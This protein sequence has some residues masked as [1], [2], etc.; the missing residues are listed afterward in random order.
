MATTGSPPAAI[1]RSP[2]PKHWLSWTT[3]NSSRRA[4]SSRAA[5][6]LKVRGSGNPAVHIVASSSRSIRS[7]ISLGCGTRN[8]SGSR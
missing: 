4:A 3:S 2:V 7:R 8:G 5:R 1:L 6:R